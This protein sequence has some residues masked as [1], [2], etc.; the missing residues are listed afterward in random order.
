LARV[1]RIEYLTLKG[2]DFYIADTG[3]PEL[4]ETLRSRLINKV[5]YFSLN[6]RLSQ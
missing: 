1:I 3:H 4:T 6:G 5:K 2:K